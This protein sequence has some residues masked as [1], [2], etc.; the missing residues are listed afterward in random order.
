MTNTQLKTL[1]SSLKKS[2]ETHG[3]DTMEKAAKS[4]KNK[5]DYYNDVAQLDSM[6]SG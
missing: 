1:V 4:F 2:A 3:I 6:H 5:D